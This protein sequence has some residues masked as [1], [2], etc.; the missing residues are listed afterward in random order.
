MKSFVF[1]LAFAFL[2]M[3]TVYFVDCCCGDF[4]THKNACTGCQEDSSKPCDMHPSRQFSGDCCKGKAK[5]APTKHQHHKKACAHVTPSS[6]VTVQCAVVPSPELIS[7]DWAL[8]D[9][10]FSPREETDRPAFLSEVVPRSS[11]RVPL[12]LL[13]SV[14][15]V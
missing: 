6:E 12:H 3:Q 7:F 15:L 13:I 1:L 8:D 14:L 9:V 4:C 5:S 11:S 2:P 10:T